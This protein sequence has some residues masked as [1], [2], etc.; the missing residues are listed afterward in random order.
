M[1]TRAWRIWLKWRQVHL[2]HRM[3]YSFTRAIGDT[4]HGKHRHPDALLL[5]TI[6]LG[7]LLELCNVTRTHLSWCYIRLIFRYEALYVQLYRVSIQHWEYEDLF[8]DTSLLVGGGGNVGFRR[9]RIGIEYHPC[10]RKQP[11][12]LDCMKPLALALKDLE[13]IVGMCTGIPYSLHFTASCYL[14]KICIK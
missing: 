7:A 1:G 2:R 4:N 5:K 6:G 14:W 12:V 11:L 3:R 10:I 9:R 8:K 13:E